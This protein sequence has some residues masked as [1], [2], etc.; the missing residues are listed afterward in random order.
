M[1]RR[2]QRQERIRV[3]A[4]ALAALGISLGA[5]LALLVAPVAL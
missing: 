5:Y 4:V 3:E 2:R 1:D